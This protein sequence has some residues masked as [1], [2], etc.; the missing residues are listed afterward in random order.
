MQDMLFSSVLK[1]G[2]DSRETD[3]RFGGPGDEEKNRLPQWKLVPREM[4]M[5][6]SNIS[7]LIREDY[8]SIEDKVKVLAQIHYAFVRIH[9][10]PDG[11]GR[12]AR[13]LTDQIAIFL[14]LPPAMAGYP[15]HDKKRRENYHKAV[16]T[17][18]DDASCE[19]LSIWIKGY[20][21]EQLKLLA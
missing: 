12:V 4:S 20:I 9:P 3:V 17:C 15:R 16:T 10:F 6:A 13:V 2:G 1:E 5:L 8:D 14:G 21:E 7:K 19:E 18:A 11:N